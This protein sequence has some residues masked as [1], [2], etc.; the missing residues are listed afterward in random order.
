MRRHTCWWRALMAARWCVRTQPHMH[1]L[2]LVNR[3]M[4]CAAVWG[5]QSHCFE[6]HTRVTPCREPRCPA[7]IR[8]LWLR[9]AVLGSLAPPSR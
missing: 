5:A 7:K 4:I 1:E 8:S 3:G 6:L 2:W 9:Q